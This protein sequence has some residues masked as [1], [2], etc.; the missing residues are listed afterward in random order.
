MLFRPLTSSKRESCT[1][2]IT[3]ASMLIAPQNQMARGSNGAINLYSTPPGQS[4]LTEV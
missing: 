4:T 3:T 1:S 2:A